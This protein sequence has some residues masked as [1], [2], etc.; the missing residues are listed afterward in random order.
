MISFMV[1]ERGKPIDGQMEVS[2]VKAARQ[3]FLNDC[4]LG[5]ASDEY[6]T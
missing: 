1:N 5:S 3:P 4:S 2:P 6:L